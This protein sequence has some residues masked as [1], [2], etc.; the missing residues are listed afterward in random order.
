MP[1]FG[2]HTGA[3]LSM[4]TQSPPGTVEPAVPPCSRLPTES[5]PQW[6]QHLKTPTLETLSQDERLTTWQAL[7][8][9]KAC[10][11]RHGKGEDV[12]FVWLSPTAST[13][14]MLE[15]TAC[16][17]VR[18]AAAGECTCGERRHNGSPIAAAG[19]SGRHAGAGAV[20][21]D[22]CASTGRLAIVCKVAAV[23][24][25]HLC[26]DVYGVQQRWLCTAFWCFC[27]AS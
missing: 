4:H 10:A 3:K 2:S 25:A 9:G 18:C 17:A 22:L 15:E 27:R 5:E 7:A 24:G 26:G 1:V 12:S 11:D 19:T 6:S 21:G 16:G 13:C 14:A 23:R 8:P 20:G